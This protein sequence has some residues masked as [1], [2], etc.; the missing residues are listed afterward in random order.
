MQRQ[1]V[2]SSNIESI[3]YEVESSTLEIA[4]LNGGVYQYSSVPESVYQG[5]MRAGSHGTYLEDHIK[6]RYGHRKI[7]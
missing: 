4:F 1:H 6:N 2:N 7:R 3:G 5:L